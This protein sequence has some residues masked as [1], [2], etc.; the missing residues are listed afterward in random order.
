[1]KTGDF[2]P[3]FSLAGTRSRIRISEGDGAQVAQAK[4]APRPERAA[5]GGWACAAS[6][7]F[8][9]SEYRNEPFSW[10]G[11]RSRIRTSEEAPTP[12]A[13]RTGAQRAALCVRRRMARRLIR[14]LP[15]P[16]PFGPSA[17]PPVLFANPG[18]WWASK[19]RECVPQRSGAA[20]FPCAGSVRSSPPRLPRPFHG[21]G[22]KPARHPDPAIRPPALPAALRASPPPRGSLLPSSPIPGRHP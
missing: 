21:P 19:E 5:E 16:S 11:T 13:Q 8:E 4:D 10:V 1:M 22:A 17:E 18:E 14:A 3:P 15:V 20:G 12:Q 2:G 6:A 9:S 7:R